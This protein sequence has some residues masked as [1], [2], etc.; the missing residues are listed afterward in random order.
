MNYPRKREAWSANEES[1]LSSGNERARFF[2]LESRNCWVCF[3][4]VPASSNGKFSLEPHHLLFVL[5]VACSSGIDPD[6]LA[7]PVVSGART[8]IPNASGQRMIDE[9]DV[10]ESWRVSS[11]YPTR[12]QDND[13]DSG[14]NSRFAP[15]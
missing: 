8:K 6:M 10:R 12:L 14:K 2:V 3:P 1:E 4:T 13:E 5:C 15:I 9:T 11:A 7:H